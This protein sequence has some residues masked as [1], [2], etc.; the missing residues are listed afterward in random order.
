MKTLTLLAATWILSAAAGEAGALR[1]VGEPIR[2][3]YVVVLKDGAARRGDAP[4][5]WGP[6]VAAVAGDL[7]RAHGA[8]VERVFEHALL[9][10]S[11]RM[12]AERAAALAADPRVDYVEEDGVVRL[13]TTQTERRGASTASTSAPVA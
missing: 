8:R 12:T 5:L 11:A 10:F 13:E 3:E 7:A 9:G 2:D 1:H 4:A 6:S